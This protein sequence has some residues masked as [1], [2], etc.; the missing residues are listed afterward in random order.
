MN[1]LREIV[2][3]W[4][5]GNGYDGLYLSDGGQYASESEGCGCRLDDLM[6]CNEPGI[7]CAAGYRISCSDPDCGCGG[8]HIGPRR[9]DA[10]T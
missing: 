10:E 6:P 3:E 5:R 8:W 1:S 4:L 9:D 7:Q 2:A